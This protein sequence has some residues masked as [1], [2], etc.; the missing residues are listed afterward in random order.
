MTMEEY[1]QYETEKALRNSKV[2]NWKTATYGKIQYVEDINDLRFFETKFPAILYDDALISESDFSSKPTV[3]PQH[4]DEVNLK[5]KTSLSEY[6]DEEYDVISYNDLFPFNIF[7][8]NDLKL[9]TDNDDDKIDIKQSSGE[10]SI[11]PLHNLTSVDVGTYAQGSNKLLETS[12]DAISKFFIAEIFIAESS[13]NIT[14]WNYFNEGMLIN[15]VKILYVS[16]GIP[17]D[18]MLFYKDEMKLELV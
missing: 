10:I 3:S 9:D 5:N 8:V 6:D 18:S 2:Y 15:L 16:F 7:S 11:E 13:V 17:F 14:S 4:V 12:H 1:V